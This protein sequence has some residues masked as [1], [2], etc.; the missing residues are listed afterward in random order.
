M[1]YLCIMKIL[2]IEDE[3]ILNKNICEALS[4]DN[5]TV[6]SVFDGFLAEKI[7]RREKFDCVIMDINMPKKNG[8]D[9]CTDFRKY[10]TKT[11]IL[12]LTAFNELEDKIK[13]FDS[14][15]DDYLTK[16]FYMR[17]LILRIRALIKRSELKKENSIDY[18]FADDIIIDLRKKTVK[19]QQ[20]I[21]NLTP[22]EFQILI[23]LCKD[24]GEIIS[25]NYLLKQIWGNY[26]ESNTNVVEVFI[27]MLRNKIDKPF[28][29]NSIKTKVGYGYYF[30]TE[31]KNY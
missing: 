2:V 18:I 29:K 4:A 5:F 3:A 13:G 21:I 10:D 7:L 25:K 22:R 11:P 8:Y 14:G 23:E 26:A 17:E 24:T 12:I 30:D 6:E 20:Q 28:N 1:Q 15:A 27:N 19:R 16:P 9:L 31:T